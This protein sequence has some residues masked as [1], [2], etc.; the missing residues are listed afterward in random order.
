MSPCKKRVQF[1]G[2]YNYFKTGV[3]TAWHL[4]VVTTR[5]SR[6]RPSDC[7]CVR[8]LLLVLTTRLDRTANRRLKNEIRCVGN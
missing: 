7:Q 8:L 3:W 2:V 6:L 4:V 5:W 1:S